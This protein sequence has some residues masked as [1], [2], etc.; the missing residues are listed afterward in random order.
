MLTCCY[1]ERT[2]PHFASVI[3]L[4]TVSEL[5]RTV[6]GICVK[7]KGS[8]VQLPVAG[9]ASPLVLL[10]TTPFWLQSDAAVEEDLGLGHTHTVTV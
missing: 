4:Q 6:K 8:T 9:F 2:R 5:L 1:E 10:L 7:M 3:Y